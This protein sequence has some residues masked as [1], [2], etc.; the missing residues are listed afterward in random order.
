[1]ATPHEIR[2]EQLCMMRLR[3]LVDITVY[4][5]AHASFSREDALSI[6]EHARSE[7]LKLCPGKEAVFELVLRPRF[8]RI[9][10]ERALAEW[11]IASA[12]N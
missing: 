8:M 9:I 6:I 2:E 3:R 5:L 12:M 11:G 7:I 4:W 1:M 10:N